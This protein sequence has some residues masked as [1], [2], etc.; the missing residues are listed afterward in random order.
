M[1]CVAIIEIM[2]IRAFFLGIDEGVER[3]K[4]LSAFMEGVPYARYGEK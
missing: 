2:G 3:A 4:M 1:G